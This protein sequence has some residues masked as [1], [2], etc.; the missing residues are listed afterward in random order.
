M[1]FL[2]FS[3]YFQRVWEGVWEAVFAC[4]W[5]QRKPQQT[6]AKEE[7][8]SEIE[9]ELVLILNYQKL[10]AIFESF[11][12]S[13]VSGREG[14]F[15]GQGGVAVATSCLTSCTHSFGTN[16]LAPY[17]HTASHTG[18]YSQVYYVWLW[19]ESMQHFN[20]CVS[21]RTF[22]CVRQG[23][24][25]REVW[26][27]LPPLSMALHIINLGTA[28]F[29]E[30][31]FCGFCAQRQNF[32][33]S[34][35]MHKAARRT[36]YALPPSLF[37]SLSLSTASSATSSTCGQPFK[38]TTWG[39]AGLQTLTAPHSV[40]CQPPAV[41]SCPALRSTLCQPFI[42]WGTCCKVLPS[43]CF[44]FA[45]TSKIKVTMHVSFWHWLWPPEPSSSTLPFF[46]PLC[47]H[48]N[49]TTST[50]FLRCPCELFI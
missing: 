5:P 39:S 34:Y 33:C 30:S 17:T 45:C 2:Q 27:D 7:R 22:A 12:L 13:A 46:L 25:I 49:S 11:A 50:V 10:F 38:F 48:F 44:S 29:A 24:G 21:W 35:T 31:I 8:E 41:S 36:R 6:Q 42:S 1:Y 9:W 20:M 3:K 15:R 40:V 4:V 18:A 16:S 43:F 37:H 26:V 19:P 32:Q 47:S 28:T 14:T 23:G